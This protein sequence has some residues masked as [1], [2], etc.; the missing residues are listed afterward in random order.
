[1]D[2]D[3]FVD[4]L[5]EESKALFEKAK[6]SDD[7]FTKNTYLHAS[8]LLSLSYLESCV[9]SIIS[10]ILVV[11]YNNEYGIMEQSVLLE[12]DIEFEG[13]QFQ[14][15]RKLKMSRLTDRIELLNYIIKKQK[16][17]PA[18]TWFTVLK[19]SIDLRNKLVHPKEAVVLTEK[20]VENALNSVLDTVNHLY[21]TVYKKKLPSY[22]RGLSSKYDLKR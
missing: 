11:P 14:L 7:L 19:Q 6:S 20:Q 18:D 1:M 22:N 13:G 12:K 15:S 9:N 21:I 17:T 3:E 8:L 2:F 5:M 10:E 16:I 4:S